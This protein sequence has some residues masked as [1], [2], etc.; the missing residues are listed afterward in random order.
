MDGSP[1][2]YTETE[3]QSR[4]GAPASARIQINEKHAIQTSPDRSGQR[5][6]C[7]QAALARKPAMISTAMMKTNFSFFTV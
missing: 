4:I 5:A 2:E 3:K 1:G 6:V 7:A